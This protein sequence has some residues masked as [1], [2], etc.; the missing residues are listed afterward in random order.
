[1]SVRSVFRRRAVIQSATPADRTSRRSSSRAR[2]C[3]VRVARTCVCVRVRACV[4]TCVRACARV[5]VRQVCHLTCPMCVARASTT[6]ASYHM[7]GGSSTR[8]SPA[9][10]APNKRTTMVVNQ[11][12]RVFSSLNAT[13]TPERRRTRPPSA[14]CFENNKEN[15]DRS[16][17]YPCP[18]PHLRHHA[19]AGSWKRGRAHSAVE[20]WTE[21][22][23]SRPP[24]EWGVAGRGG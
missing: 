6:R 9:S 19:H 23:S 15:P 14:S 11:Q 21:T 16:Q 8:R 5:R 4:R 1:M 20:L 7:S 18:H 12:N 22:D 13:K 17:P 10:A 24:F 3:V 2:A